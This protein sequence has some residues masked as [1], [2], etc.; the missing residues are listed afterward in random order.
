MESLEPRWVL[1][2]G[3]PDTNFNGT[4]V[5]Q[6]HFGAAGQNNSDYHIVAQPDG[7]VVIA[8][9]FND[10]GSVFVVRLN[11]D[12]TLDNSFGTNGEVDVTMTNTN[13][14]IVGL[15]VEPSGQI[16]VGGWGDT[17]GTDQT[18][19]I[20]LNSDGSLDKTFGT[21]GIDEIS[22]L[23]VQITGLAL[24]SDGSYVV[25]QSLFFHAYR[26]N[27]DGTYDNTFNTG[28]AAVALI[29]LL[30]PTT[31]ALDV[32]ALTEGVFVES[33]QKILTYGFSGYEPATGDVP[34]FTLVRY[35]SD[36]TLDTTFGNGGAV[37][38]P[39]TAEPNGEISATQVIQQPDGKF[40]VTGNPTLGLGASNQGF[41][42]ARYNENGTRDTTFNGGQPIVTSVPGFVESQS[43]QVALEPDGGILV[44][45]IVQAGPPT[46]AINFA[47]LRFNSD[48]SPDTTFG[49]NGAAVTTNAN[50]DGNGSTN[51]LDNHLG[52]AV[53]PND[54]VFVV[55][56]SLATA[57]SVVVAAVT[58][59]SGSVSTTGP[60]AVADSAQTIE[61]VPVA[62]N[63]LAND[64]PGTGGAIAPSTVTIVGQPASGTVQV[65]PLT[66]VVTYSP[67]TSY[68]GSDSFTYTV[69]DV[70]GD[71]SNVATVSVTVNPTPVAPTAVNDSAQ[72][73]KNV[74]V[75]INVLANDV[76]G[77]GGAIAPSTVTIAGQPAHGTVQVNSQ[78]GL[79]TYTPA[80]GF[81]GNDSFTYTVKDVKGDVS[82]VATVS[83]VVAAVATTPPHANSDAA[84]T[85][86]HTPV[87]INVLAN[88]TAGTNPIDPTTVAIVQQ[89]ADG[90]VQIN[91]ATGTVTYSPSGGF[92]GVDSFT[93]TVSDT[94][95]N[96]SNVAS[97][98]ITVNA[99]PVANNDLASTAANTPVTINVL[100][101][102]HP[103]QSQAALVPG[104]LKIVQQPQNGTAQMVGGQIVYTPAAGF[105][106]GNTLQYTVTD[107]NGL[108]S[109]VAT[110]AIRVGAAVEIS[111]YAY[112]DGNG[113]GEIDPGE[114]GIPG[115]TIELS[116]TDG[117]YTFTTYTTTRS[118]GSYHFAEGSNYLLPQG[119]Y[120]V[121]EIQPGFFVPGLAANGTPAAAGPNTNSQFTG[122]ALAAGQQGSGYDF[123]AQGPAAQFASAYSNGRVFLASNGPS[124]PGLNLANGT[125][126]FSFDAG[127]DGTL[128]A[129]AQFSPALGSVNLTLLNGAMNVIATSTTGSGQAQLSYTGLAAGP[130]FLEVSG[131]NTNVSL[132]ATAPS[133]QV[134]LPP[135]VQ[136][137][138]HNA[139]NPLDVNGDGIVSA[140]DALAV[141][142]DLNAGDGGPL[143]TLSGSGNELVDVND[144]GQLTAIDALDIINE[145]NAAAAAGTVAA[146][147]APGLARAA[148]ASALATEAASGTTWTST[149]PADD[150]ADVGSV[151]FAL[152]AAQSLAQAAPAACPASTSTGSGSPGGTQN[153]A[154]LVGSA[155]VPSA[156][157]GLGGSAHRSSPRTAAGNVPA[158]SRLWSDQEI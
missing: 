57:S 144:D 13:W 43:D 56:T 111:G 36:G 77:S 37:Q 116:K 106:G 72:T 67:A 90:T 79:V 87:A 33:D 138:Y 45:G 121:K 158:T 100:A 32:S 34:E 114:A 154:G 30:F 17:G 55:S 92:I 103:S 63:V 70:N 81:A 132:N 74:P 89:P 149:A 99:P 120:S 38:T 54:T 140:L 112:V 151:A 91:P 76:P 148:V 11:P 84:A 27:H 21:A 47:I 35:N 102:D 1:S 49:T 135:P 18:T 23:D 110:V 25:S 80:A 24:Q 62:I 12:G 78:S 5:E 29:S 40:L 85:G 129:L 136:L 128:T 101:N 122:L 93:Y 143:S 4:G 109:N 145:L 64:T 10:L 65:S 147:A 155:A 134:S 152:A 137:Q 53:S 52:L 107:A 124:F 150:S 97:V 42:L 94:K 50:L 3:Q 133:P 19:L 6:I 113:N 127:V 98:S 48:G 131:T 146:G 142:N 104:S 86:E 118:D 115:V 123:G 71:V 58:G 46:G 22:K 31:S 83:I 117:G 96:V 139:V 14:S 66:G 61:N 2:G 15:V 156:T 28:P 69:K 126:W 95:G 141:I 44:A 41:V 105:V 125:Y 68:V 7:K 130:L 75:A 157:S 88:D 108:T 8:G 9:T 51:G 60:T 20:R 59:G 26:I 73:N 153:G 82:N 39:I 119:T 16:T